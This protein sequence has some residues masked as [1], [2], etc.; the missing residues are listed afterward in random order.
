M[1]DL[2]KY[3]SINKKSIVKSLSSIKVSKDT[4]IALYKVTSNDT[5]NTSIINTSIYNISYINGVETTHICPSGSM[6]SVGGEYRNGILNWSNFNTFLDKPDNKKL[7]EMYGDIQSYLKYVL[8]E[9]KLEFTIE[10]P[11]FEGELH[12]KPIDYIK[13]FSITW[14]N[15]YCE[16]ALDLQLNQLN[17]EFENIMKLYKQDDLVFF[18]SLINKFTNDNITFRYICNNIMNSPKVF[19]HDLNILGQKITI[20]YDLE[21]Q[22]KYDI[23]YDIWKEIAINQRVSKLVTDNITNGFPLMGPH[24]LI[25]TNK[26]IKL[27]DNPEQ[28]KKI[29]QSE[30]AIIVKDLLDS[31]ITALNTPTKY[32]P[33]KDVNDFIVTKDHTYAQDYTEEDEFWLL[34]N[35]IRYDKNHAHNFI[36]SDTA[37][38][39]IS[40]HSGRTIYD[41]CS[42]TNGGDL[43]SDSQFPIFNKYMFQLCYNLYCLNTKIHC[44][45]RDLHMNNIILS[46][47]FN[48][49][50]DVHIEDPKILYI[51]GKQKFIFPNNFHNVCLIDF[52]ISIINPELFLDKKNKNTKS[53]KN[54]EDIL[55]I[56]ISQLL[57]YLYNI[58]PEYEQ[59]DQFLRGN[60]KYYYTSYFKLLSVLDIYNICSKFLAFLKFNKKKFKTIKISKSKSLLEAI[61][62]L[63]DYHITVIFDDLI[64]TNDHSKFLKMEWPVLS[65]INSTF[66][67]NVYKSGDEESITDIFT[68]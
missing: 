45:H 31:A 22:N 36:I 12:I 33:L 44:I 66:Q 62:K 30:V 34:R 52:N 61:L 46:P 4:I 11:N 16:L 1:N 8:I 25:K 29:K 40:E 50:V 13:I 18:K 23:K 37:I 24:F 68:I 63:S 38:N 55:G 5:N 20:L 3:S 60:M 58:K 53:I 35:N 65:I 49:S 10:Y 47:L 21:L 39:M 54:N 59:Y 7:K 27:F 48:G 28:Y 15:F 67:E 51:I 42:G 6:K 32:K 26:I 64:N 14:F 19:L 17:T 41:I 57:Y 9:R 56:Q 43:F 2:K